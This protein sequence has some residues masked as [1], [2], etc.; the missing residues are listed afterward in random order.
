M[1]FS[2]RYSTGVPGV[3]EMICGGVPKNSVTIVSGPPGIG[4]SNFAM[5]F[6]I[7]GLEKGE[8]GIYLTVEDVPDTV[9]NYGKA[10]GWDFTKYEKSNELAI[11]SQ[12]SYGQSS[13]GATRT[14]GD[15]IKKVKAQRLVLDSV[16]LF[17]YLFKDD[18]SQRVNLLNFI[19]EVKEAGCTSVLTA[20]QN[21][22]GREIK[23]L[24]EHFLA[25]GLFQLFWSTHR[26]RNERCFRVVK[27]RGTKIN[28]DIRP[29][30]IGDKGI[31]VYPTQ[32]PLSLAE[33]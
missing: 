4:K 14:I 17:R 21:E 6:I 20:E 22:G 24:D 23:Y 11:L 27:M 32:V 25:D 18:V 13:T 12:T 19:K 28:A 29:M 1:D 8:P 33:K 15:A 30:D 10:F 3:D 31:I 7:S 5:Q 2:K 16:T 9:R 26:E